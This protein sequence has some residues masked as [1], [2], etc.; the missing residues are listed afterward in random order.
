MFF[1]INI[2]CYSEIDIAKKLELGGMWTFLVL[3]ETCLTLL[4]QQHII[5]N[6]GRNARIVLAHHFSVQILFR[7]FQIA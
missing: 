1:S 4:A 3:P 6:E 2:L 7:G 5:S